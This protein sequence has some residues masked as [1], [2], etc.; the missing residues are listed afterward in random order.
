[1]ESAKLAFDEVVLLSHKLGVDVLHLGMDAVE[2]S[3]DR[4]TVV[5]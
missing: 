2:N 1:M 5:C 3:A 4:Y